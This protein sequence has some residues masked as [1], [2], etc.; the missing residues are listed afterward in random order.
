MSKPPKYKVILTD[1][2]G[3]MLLMLVPFLGPL[4]GP[5]G[6]PLLLAGLGLL[7]LN[8]DWAKDA[9]VYAKKHSESLR[10]VFFPNIPWVKWAWDIFAVSLLIGGTIMNFL[11]HGNTFLVLVSIVIMASSTTIFMLNRNRLDWLYKALKK[12]SKSQ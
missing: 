1:T 2:A 12:A 7:A 4:P 11:V 9:L 5:G 6:I 10:N 8:H 3:V